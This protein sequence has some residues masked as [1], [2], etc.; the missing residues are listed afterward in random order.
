MTQALDGHEVLVED[1]FFALLNR[2]GVAID[3]VI[4]PARPAIVDVLRSLFGHRLNTVDTTSHRPTRDEQLAFPA[5]L[6]LRLSFEG[7]PPVT[8]CGCGGDFILVPP[9]LGAD[10]GA[11]QQ[12]VNGPAI[13]AFS[14]V[15]GRRLTDAATLRDQYLPDV[16]GVVLR[17]G[18]RDLLFAAI[19]GRA[20]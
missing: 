7:Q 13:H 6:D 9:A 11:S 14:G 1:L 10:S 19:D 18:D 5:M 8:A 20:T 17:F 3:E 2:L 15:V 12:P 4:A 16:K